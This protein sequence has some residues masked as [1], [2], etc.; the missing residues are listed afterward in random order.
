M[1]EKSP[2]GK[3][4]DLVWGSGQRQQEERPK[5]RDQ[6]GDEK[7]ME[8]VPRVMWEMKG[9]EN[10]REDVYLGDLLTESHAFM[11]FRSTESGVP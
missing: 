11:R 8:G 9:S 1:W 10:I 6:G 2:G 4:L 7:P 3:G 5:L